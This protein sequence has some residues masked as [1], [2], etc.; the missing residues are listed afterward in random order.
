MQI[1][2][3]SVG[4]TVELKFCLPR[5]AQDG[6]HWFKYSSTDGWTEY[7]AH[8]AFNAAR[9][10][11]TLTLK[12]GSIGDDD[13]VAN[14]IIMDPSGLGI[15]P[16]GG[17]PIDDG[18]GGGGGG[19]CFVATA[20]F[21]SPFERHVEMLREFRDVYLM[22]SGVGRAFVKAYYMHSP[23]VADFIAKHDGLRVVVRWSLLPLVG[24]SWMA[25]HFGL[26]WVPLSLLALMIALLGATI[27]KGK[28]EPNPGHGVHKV[29]ESTFDNEK[30]EVKAEI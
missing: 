6:Y 20:A 23:P 7:S 26:W 15:A 4:G 30:I 14:G 22:S 12:D 10:E 21:G 2:V 19:G 13:G 17:V 25:V 8:A 5:P 16:A 9:D 27:D 11:V 18:G 28:K 24:V 29:I 3:D 1:K